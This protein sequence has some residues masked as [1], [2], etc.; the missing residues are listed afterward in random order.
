[1]ILIIM[2]KLAIGQVNPID[3]TYPAPGKLIDVG[4]RKLHLFCSGKGSPTIILEAGGGA[5]AIDWFLVQSGI[6]STTRVCSYDRAGLGWSDPGPA[7]E[8]VEQTIRDLH[9][10]ILAAGEKK[11]Y[12]LVGASIGGIF[13]QAYQ[14]VYPD[15]V[16][17][18]VFSN[19]SNRV[20]LVVKEKTDLLWNL[21]EDEIKSI[22][23]MPPS[24]NGSKKPSVVTE[25][26]NRL[27]AQQQAMRL[28]L[29]ILLWK[30]WNSTTTGPEAM[31]S[32]RKEFLREFEQTEAGKKPP[33]GR[34]PVLVLSGDP[35]AN[36][37]VLKTRDAA[38]DRLDFLSANT[39]HITAVDAGHEIHLYQPNVVIDGLKRIVLAVKRGVPL[40]D[41]ATQAPG[42]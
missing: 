7:D 8:T 22:Y 32:W 18:L 24:S 4:G 39:M 17:G 38:G 11:P 29:T 14:Q 12:I 15:E 42:N 16:A 10:L 23:P 35:A 33:L 2:S 25:P 27:P 28:W 9:Q 5:F 41:S 34:L 30:K 6:E 3:S 40:S 31:L 19:S 36:D 20:G 1:M 21:S 26:F 37:S 13:I